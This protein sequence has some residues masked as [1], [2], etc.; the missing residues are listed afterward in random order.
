MDLRHQM[1]GNVYND[2]IYISFPCAE[3]TPVVA[4]NNLAY[5]GGRRRSRTAVWMFS[6]SQARFKI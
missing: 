4:V 1:I 5:P 6:A 3:H 2:Y